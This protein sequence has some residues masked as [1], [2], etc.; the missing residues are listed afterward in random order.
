ML[1]FFARDEMV[2]GLGEFF[3]TWDAFCP[4][5]RLRGAVLRARRPFQDAVILSR[6]LRL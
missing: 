1:E 3:D 5:T 4:P 2:V 6:R